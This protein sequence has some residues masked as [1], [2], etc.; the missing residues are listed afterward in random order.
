MSEKLSSKRLGFIL[1][2]GTGLEY[3]DFVVYGLLSNYISQ[4]FFPAD[5]G[6]VATLNTFLIFALG[7]LSRPFGAVI[8]GFFSDLIS[9]SKTLLI[10]M[11]IMG[12][13]SV[14]IALLPGYESIGVFAPILLTLLRVLQGVAMGAEMPNSMSFLSRFTSPSTLARDYAPIGMSLS[15]AA[16]IA[17][18]LVFTI[19]FAVGDKLMSEGFWR[20]PFLLGGAVAFLSFYM[21]RIIPHQDSSNVTVKE[22]LDDLVINI[23]TVALLLGSI[24]FVGS[25]I[26]QFYFIIS[27]AKQNLNYPAHSI[28]MY[29]NLANVTIVLS[30]YL[31]SKY[32]DKIGIKKMLMILYVVAII[33]EVPL[34]SLINMGDIHLIGVFAILQN[35]IIGGL[36]AT[37]IPFITEMFTNTSR[38]TL[39]GITYNLL[40]TI[41]G[42]IR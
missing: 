22:Y 14:L 8:F 24:I 16:G 33:A 32:I 17:G 29:Y 6:W 37:Y 12:G 35:I 3:Y 28:D 20:V 1:G 2:I 13:A 11:L 40:A 27:Y 42:F 5:I 39:V 23:K 31:F 26:L 21:R 30:I 36:T 4:T 34:L 25:L 38:T 41:C 15:I 19:E 9:P 7:Y 10:T 18:F